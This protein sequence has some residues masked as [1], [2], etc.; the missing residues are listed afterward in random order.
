MYEVLLEKDLDAFAQ[1]GHCHRKIMMIIGKISMI[2]ITII[3]I[4][5]R[6]ALDNWL[7]VQLT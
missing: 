4:L 7:F 1:V 6:M 5:L 3:M 2:M